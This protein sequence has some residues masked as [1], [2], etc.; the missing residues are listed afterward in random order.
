MYCINL[1]TVSKHSNCKFKN[2]TFSA[3]L[4]VHLSCWSVLL[5]ISCSQ[6]SIY[7]Y[8]INVNSGVGTT[9]VVA[10]LAKLLFITCLY[11]SSTVSC[12]NPIYSFMRT[13]HHPLSPPP[14]PPPSSAR[15]Q[16]LRRQLHRAK[17]RS[18]SLKQIVSSTCRLYAT[19]LRLPHNI[20]DQEHIR[21]G[22]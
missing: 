19:I 4:Q 15:V 8:F 12:S 20:G 1:P 18:N 14:P 16:Q 17:Q 3:R 21:P 10:T 2:K 6:R 13:Q 9:A 22:G 5:T 11:L 7:E